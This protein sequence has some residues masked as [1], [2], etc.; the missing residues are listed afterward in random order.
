MRELLNTPAIIAL[1]ALNSTTVYFV[2]AGLAQAMFTALVF[3]ETV[4]YLVM[5]KRRILPWQRCSQD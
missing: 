2:P 5:W 3:A 1:A 4:A